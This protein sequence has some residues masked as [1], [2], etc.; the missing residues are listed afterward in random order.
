[1]Y[2]LFQKQLVANKDVLVERN[3][4]ISSGDLKLHFYETLIQANDVEIS[5]EM[6]VICIMI[7][8]EKI[9]ELEN[10][11]RFKYLPGQ[12]LILPP[13]KK[14]TL[15]FPT[16]SRDNPTQCLVFQPDSHLVKEATN[17]YYLQTKELNAQQK[18]NKVDFSFDMIVRDKAISRNVEH[19]IKLFK[20]NVEHQDLFIKM[21]AKELLIRILQSK[22]R[23][24]FLNN[25]RVSEGD[26]MSKIA[27]YIDE[28][29]LRSISI[30][31]LSQQA[32][33]SRSNFFNLFKNA[34]GISPNEYIINKKIEKAKSIISSSTNQSISQIAYDLGYSDSS[35]F[36]KQ[37]KTIT[38]YT[39]KQFLRLTH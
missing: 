19:L 14:L 25:F 16:A 21:A 28:N 39:P 10:G 33:M 23:R 36:S 4:F 37:F 20:E 2:D 3:A 26:R 30:E 7:N 34:F 8:G 31:E 32:N 11:E 22:A 5:F 13:H 27:D 1:M 35:Y 29:I 15:D 38:G 17:T 6:P 9:I 18:V 12:I 24:I